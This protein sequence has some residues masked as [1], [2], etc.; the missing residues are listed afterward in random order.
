MTLLEHLNKV[1]TLVNEAEAALKSKEYDKFL[2]LISEICFKTYWLRT[3]LQIH[4]AKNKSYAS[5]QNL[6]L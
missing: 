1:K 6:L 2:N 3:Q 4:W 5:W